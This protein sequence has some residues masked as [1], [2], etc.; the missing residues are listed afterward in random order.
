MYTIFLKEILKNDINL[1]VIIDKDKESGMVYINEIDKYN[2][3]ELDEI[4]NKTM[5]KLKDQL[6]IIIKEKTDMLDEIKT[7]VRRITDQKYINY[8]KFED[9]QKGVKDLICSIYDEK[10]TIANDL[11]FNII[12]TQK[13]YTKKIEY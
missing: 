1:N 4:V 7:H 11:A 2:H 12:H 3:M 8:H 5:E 10:K 13:K 9:I 6:K